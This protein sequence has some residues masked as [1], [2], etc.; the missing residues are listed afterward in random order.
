MMLR[1]T[2]MSPD[3][4]AGG[5][6]TAATVADQPDGVQSTDGQQSGQGAEPAAPSSPSAEPTGTFLDDL[7][8][9]LR[10]SE[11]LERIARSDNPTVE[12]ARAFV[13]TKAK[14]GAHTVK[15]PGQN[16][17]DEERTEFLRSIGVPEDKTEYQFPTENLPAVE[18]ED[19]EQQQI[20]DIA[21]DVGLT[22][23]QAAILYRRYADLKANTEQELQQS[24]EQARK[25]AEQQLRR[26]TGQ[27]YDETLQFA[28][29]TIQTFFPEEFKQ[30][31]DD[32][33]LGNDSR[34]IK[35][36][37]E[38][39]KRISSDEIIGGGRNQSMK[40]SPAEAEQ[41][42]GQFMADPEN[43]KALVDKNHPGH[44]AATE[45]RSELYRAQFPA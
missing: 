7:P 36:L 32:S 19:K 10:G 6:G 12:L 11:S 1:D 2:L 3:A 16:A 40:L 14:V 5:T 4:D 18:I 44:K 39:R 13:Q 8:D 33:G 15:V 24:S 45:K 41:E 34:L 17:S 26:D 27:A 30:F 22:K 43:R 21:H 38:V 9:D 20:R 25:Q 28:Q 42:L 31:L 29:E 35:G 37:A 23:E